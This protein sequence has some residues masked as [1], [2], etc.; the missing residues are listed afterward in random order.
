M[1]TARQNT[2]SA[3]TAKANRALRAASISG[4]TVKCVGYGKPAGTVS[5]PVAN[6]IISRP[7]LEAAGIVLFPMKTY[8]WG[9]QYIIE[10]A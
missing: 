1:K 10:A 2:A 7:V 8:G 6:L 4:V 9:T 5:G 3:L